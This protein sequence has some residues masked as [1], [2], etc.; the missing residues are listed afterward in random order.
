MFQGP[1]EIR[2]G[3]FGQGEGIFVA[4]VMVFVA[5]RVLVFL[6]REVAVLLGGSVISERVSEGVVWEYGCFW[7]G[8]S[9][10]FSYKIYFSNKKLF[11]NYKT[12]FSKI[13]IIVEQ[14]IC[15]M[16][17]QFSKIEFSFQFFSFRKMLSWSGIT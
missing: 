8:S 13:I 10:I 4:W 17:L 7:T 1:A 9:D 11:L 3:I 14:N 12:Y 5:R 15:R 6:V 16:F 2:G